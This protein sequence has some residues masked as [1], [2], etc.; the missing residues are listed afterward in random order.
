MGKMRK[1][2]E[3]KGTVQEGEEGGSFEGKEVP[4]GEGWLGPE[5]RRVRE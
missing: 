1:G 5:L 2:M 3:S 4:R